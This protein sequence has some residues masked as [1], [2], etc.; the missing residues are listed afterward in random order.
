MRWGPRMGMDWFRHDKFGAI[1][2]WGLYSLLGQGT[3]AM[4]HGRIPHA[5]Y[6]RL[7]GEFRPTAFDAAEWARVADEAGMRY[8]ALTTRHHDGYCLFDS[9]ASGFTSIKQGPGR[10]FVAEY[11]EAF[12]ARGLKVGFYY[13]LSD[14]RYPGYFEPQKYP[15][16]AAAMV[17][18]AHEQIRE[19]LV[20]YG[21]IDL[22]WFDGQWMHRKWDEWKW[23]EGK[24]ELIEFWRADELE[25]MIRDLQPG[26]IFNNRMAV[27]G[28]YR[29]VE[30]AVSVAEPERGVWETV[31]TIGDYW[32]SWCDQRYTPA[33][34]RKSAK[35]LIVQ[36]IIITAKGGNLLLNMAPRADGELQ[37]EEVAILREVGRWLS[38]NGE[39]IYGTS[40]PPG[41]VFCSCGLVTTRASDAYILMP[42]LPRDRLLVTGLSSQV[43]SARILGSDLELMV[44]RTGADRIEIPDFP[45]GTAVPEIPVVKLELDE[46]LADKRLDDEGAWVL[47]GSPADG[48]PRPIHA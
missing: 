43:R 35:Q 15:E 22:L 44:R 45:A 29:S 48:S 23:G 28:D 40:P 3:W 36:L 47:S 42:C 18:Q 46:P 25:R 26:I 2:H 10:D 16:S 33:P 14:W 37:R 8:A 41:P 24:K 1:I 39:A 9:K 12:R 4:H 38:A 5:E 20:N 19:L 30:Q 21:K 27:D 6:A 13:S 7:T 11:V 34:S 31:Q 17:D 32:E